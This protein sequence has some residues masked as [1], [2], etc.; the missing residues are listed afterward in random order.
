MVRVRQPPAGRCRRGSAT[1]P[2]WSGWMSCAL[3]HRAAVWAADQYA[4]DVARVSPDH[5]RIGRVNREE[6]IRKARRRAAERAPQREAEA[7]ERAAQLHSK[8]SAVGAPAAQRRVSAAEQSPDAVYLGPQKSP[9]EWDE[10]VGIARLT[11]IGAARQQRTIT[12]GEIKWAIFDELQMLVG[13]SMFAELMV[14]VNE[15]S[16][17]VLLSS[18]IVHQDDGKPGEGF[19]PYAREM[20]F[21][22]P[23]ETLQ[24]RAYEH[25]GTG[26]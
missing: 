13:H 22:E 1:S 3:P 23:L 11:A 25:F 20:G 4:I 14:A 12:Y 17:G 16:D 15:K 10:A 9:R 2:P 8:V 18:I 26:V 19:L 21:E 6:R 24:R 7:A 5:A